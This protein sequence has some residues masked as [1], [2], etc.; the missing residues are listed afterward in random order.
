MVN[1]KK[2]DPDSGPAA[3]YGARLRRLREERGWTQDELAVRTGYS[4]KHVSAVETGRRSS[5]LA[6]SRALDVAFG[7]ADT[8]QSCESE[9][10]KLRH[11]VLLEGFPEYVHQERRAVE[12][13][14]FEIGIVPGLLQTP[15]YARVLAASSVARGVITADQADERV[16][17]LAESQRGLEKQRPPALFVVMDESCIRRVVGGR[18]IM[19]AQLELLVEF[20]KRPLT[21]LQVA[22]FGMGEKRPFDLPV[23]LVTLPDWS[24]LAYAESQV[25]GHLERENGAVASMLAGY[26]R[27]AAESLSPADSVAMIEEVRKG[28]L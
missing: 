6:F 3:A 4:S 9:W 1:R 10:Q 28:M 11:G 14:L 2:L 24:V 19:A 22:P 21:V 17:F 13:R 23:N 26:H 16:A 5:T 15:E 27:L 12:L 25:Q 7:L 20:A 18:E 8:E